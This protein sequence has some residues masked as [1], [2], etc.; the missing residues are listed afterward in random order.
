MQIALLLSELSVNDNISS[1]FPAESDPTNM[2]GM[3]MA[4]DDIFD[5]GIGFLL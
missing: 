2:I 3:R 5:Q 4:Q 1:I